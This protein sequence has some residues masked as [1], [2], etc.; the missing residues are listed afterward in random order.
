MVK[1]IRFVKLLHTMRKFHHLIFVVKLTATFNHDA[2]F[3]LQFIPILLSKSL[4]SLNIVLLKYCFVKIKRQRN[5]ILFYS[6]L[7][8]ILFYFILLLFKKYKTFL[9]EKKIFFIFVFFFLWVWFAFAHI[10]IYSTQNLYSNVTL[11]S[12]ALA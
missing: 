4:W 12:A 3:S 9:R 1:Y 2:I 8:Y 10:F 5:I 6:I 11:L 7:F